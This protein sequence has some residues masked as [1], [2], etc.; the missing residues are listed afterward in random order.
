MAKQIRKAWVNWS[1]GILSVLLLILLI[2]QAQKLPL[3]SAESGDY[4]LHQDQTLLQML[5]NNASA[6]PL[7]GWLVKLSA[8]FLGNSPLALR[9]PGLLAGLLYFWYATAL[10]KN[11]RLPSTQILVFAYLAL[12]VFVFPWLGLAL[13]YGLGFSFMLASIFHFYKYRQLDNGH[14]LWRTCIFAALAAGSHL[15]FLPTYLSVLL[16]L[17]ILR[18]SKSHHKQPSFWLVNRPTT[19]VTAFVAL[20]LFGA[21]R[22]HEVDFSFSFSAWKIPV[23]ESLQL[24]LWGESLW[25]EVLIGISLVA[26]LGL[27]LWDSFSKGGP[28]KNRMYQELL[29]WILGSA[30]LQAIFEG[31]L[32]SGLLDLSP[33]WGFGPLFLVLVPFVLQ[34]FNEHPKGEKWQIGLQSF[35]SIGSAL[36]FVFG[37]S[38]SQN[39]LW[40]NDSHLHKVWP[41]FVEHCQ[42]KNLKPENCLLVAPGDN[43]PALQY[44]RQKQFPSLALRSASQAYKAECR[45]YLYHCREE[46]EIQVC[47]PQDD[48]PLKIIEDWGITQ[49]MQEHSKKAEL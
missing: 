32:E 37:F 36:L 31:W 22:R 6:T 34:R 11:F 48:T 33:V 38:W 8:L 25:S 29:L 17:N 19:I 39:G 28:V 24:P 23:R 15:V 1:L 4:L 41:A 35:I 45:F 13:G 5:S 42:K 14:H 10:A 20:F 46:N 40:P 16:L 47:P 44:Y 2:W 26:A 43:L 7:S 3:S 18:W 49:L 27:F 12:Q 9:V 21:Y 30:L